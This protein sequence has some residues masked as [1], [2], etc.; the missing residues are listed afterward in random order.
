MNAHS[1]E[2]QQSPDVQDL[3]DDRLQCGSHEVFILAALLDPALYPKVDTISME[4]R[5]Q[6]E[7]LVIKLQ[8]TRA[9]GDAAVAQLKDYHEGRHGIPEY[10]F[11]NPALVRDAVGFWRDYGLQNAKLKY[12]AKVAVRVLGIPPTAAGMLLPH[13]IRLHGSVQLNVRLLWRQ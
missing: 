11:E 3:F 2:A 10:A 9:H 6:A 5:I 7:T 8:P 13:S 1:P 12:I 4:E